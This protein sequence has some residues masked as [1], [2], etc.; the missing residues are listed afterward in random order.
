MPIYLIFSLTKEG[1][2]PQDFM[3]ALEVSLVETRKEEG[4]VSYNLA[5]DFAVPGFF[6][7]RKDTL[8]FVEEW[9]SFEDLQ[10]HFKK[11]H[12]AVLKE[13][14]EKNAIKSNV[15]VFEKIK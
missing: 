8:T 15:Q 6:E 1:G 2:F 12:L 11:P 4:C 14:F 9:R 13:L 7:A 10:E 3:D 5:T